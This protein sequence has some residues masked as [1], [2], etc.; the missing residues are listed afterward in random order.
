MTLYLTLRAFYLAYNTY[1]QRGDFK[2]SQQAVEKQILPNK[3]RALMVRRVG[4]EPDPPHVD[5]SGVGYANLGP[6]AY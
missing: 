5:F 3:L 4:D 2:I 1:P 6:I